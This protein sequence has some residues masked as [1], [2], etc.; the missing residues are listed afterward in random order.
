MNY[1]QIRSCDISNGP[2]IGASIFVCGCPIRCKGC[3]NDS[4]WD[5]NSGTK[6]TSKEGGNLISEVISPDYITRFSVLGGEPLAPQNIEAVSAI[7]S[8]ARFEKPSIKIW[9]W[10]G[11]T[12]EELMK[13]Y[14]TNNDIN[15]PFEQYQAFWKIYNNIDYLVDGPFIQE[16]KDLTLKFRGSKNQRIL[17]VRAMREGKTPILADI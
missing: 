9:L 6:W 17:D 3:H 1:A 8:A 2:G 16:Q 15:F 10:T 14:N 5:F 7:V 11:Y 4:I 13:K 12:W